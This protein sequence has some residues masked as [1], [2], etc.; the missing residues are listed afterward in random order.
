MTFLR[1]DR[2]QAIPKKV[3]ELEKGGSLPVVTSV[4]YDTFIPALAEIRERITN[5]IPLDDTTYRK[6][7]EV[8]VLLRD[9]GIMHLHVGREIDDDVLLLAGQTDE[10][11]LFIAL[12]RH[13]D[14]F[15]PPNYAR[16]MKRWLG[17]PWA[18]W[19]LRNQKKT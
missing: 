11:V 19:S 13:S 4:D 18:D 8:D 10:K 15:K 17:R 12:V 3:E 2:I 1:E 7:D 6:G 14:V 9:D 5:G 16:G